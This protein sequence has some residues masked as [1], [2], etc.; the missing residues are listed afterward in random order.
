[1]TLVFFSAFLRCVLTMLVVYKLLW[2]GHMLNHLE[3]IGLGLVGGSAFMTIP[4][5]L[6]AHKDGTPF[7]VWAG[8][9]FTVGVIMYLIGRLSRHIKHEKR[10][11]EA[12][13]QAR[14]HFA[15]K[16]A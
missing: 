2:W 13:K 1:M 6:D 11:A 5:I 7:D 10:N 9:V 12:L 15:G 3:R 4:V 16:H 14:G 8:I